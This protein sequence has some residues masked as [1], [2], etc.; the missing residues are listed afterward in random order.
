MI[1]EKKISEIID[2]KINI[3]VEFKPILPTA[4]VI[5]EILAS[6][7][8]T[9][10][11]YLIIGVKSKQTKNEIIGLTSDFHIMEIVSNSLK[12]LSPQINDLEHQ[13]LYISNKMLYVF[14]IRSLDSIIL[15]NNKKYIREYSK[16]IECIEKQ[17][18]V[19]EKEKLSIKVYDKTYAI[20][21]AIENYK[22][23]SSN[24]IQ[25]VKYAENDAMLFKDMLITQ[26]NVY[27]DDITIF[28]NE[29]ALQSSLKYDFQSLFHTLRENDRVIFYYVGHGFH[30]GV[31]NYLTAY[32]TH[33]F[34][35]SETSIGLRSV[36]LDPILKSK[37]KN[38]L[39]FIDA[40]ATKIEEEMGRNI[41]MG[42]D[43]NDFQ[44]ERNENLYCASFFSCQ[45]GQSSYSCH[46][47]SH[48]VWTY[49]L[50]KAISGN[51]PSTIKNEKFITDRLLVNYLGSEVP[52]YTKKNLGKEQNPKAV[53]D[54]DSE[55]VLAKI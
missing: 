45:S 27:E 11:G 30:N 13:L 53:L 29:N 7:A 22:P 34:N 55:F 39:I 41:C 51:V 31:T 14:K 23:R 46:T 24:Q 32:D 4:K 52:K 16:T 15:L 18:E 8:N 2:K 12:I 6:F 17:N 50:I 5:A 26:M 47:L 48:G 36:F 54:S 33:P 10:G 20:I 40:C 19:V 3:D 28:L 43:F 42:I 38:A 35:I 9:N 37:C 25:S 49:H 21:I 1:D 44:V